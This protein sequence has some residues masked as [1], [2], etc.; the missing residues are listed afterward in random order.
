MRR[1]QRVP[2]VPCADRCADE[3]PVG[4]AHHRTH[5]GSNSDAH[6]CTHGWSYRVADGDSIRVAITSPDGGPFCIANRTAECI[7]IGESNG[8]S[9]KCADGN[10]DKVTDRCTDTSS[11][12]PTNN[13]GT[14]AST[15]HPAN[16]G[17]ANERPNRSTDGPADQSTNDHAERAE[18]R[19]DR[20]AVDSPAYLAHCCTVVRTICTPDSEPDCHHDHHRHCHFYDHGHRIGR[21]TG[22]GGDCR[23]IADKR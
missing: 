13:G 23:G 9:D 7:A 20:G 19:A 3:T 22:R 10:A 11:N 21:S 1:E 5:R 16:N 17:V 12:R 2:S 18:Y 4:L 8:F 15:N 6:F 14:D